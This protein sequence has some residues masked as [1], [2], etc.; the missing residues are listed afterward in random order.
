MRFYKYVGEEAKKSDSIR[1]GDGGKSTPTLIGLGEGK[2]EV[3]RAPLS[4]LTEVH[5]FL[6]PN[7]YVYP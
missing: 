1:G 5:D 2:W 6:K 7:K 3:C 4:C